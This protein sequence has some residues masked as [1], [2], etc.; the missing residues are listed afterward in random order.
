MWRKKVRWNVND[1]HFLSAAFYPRPGNDE[2]DM[3]LYAHFVWAL[4][5]GSPSLALLFQVSQ[6][7]IFFSS[8]LLFFLDP[9]KK[10]QW[11]MDNDLNVK[12]DRYVL[13]F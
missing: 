9:K 8:A 7:A 12:S 2:F 3:N 6:S 1:H 10:S 11:Y 5:V 13:F 4:N